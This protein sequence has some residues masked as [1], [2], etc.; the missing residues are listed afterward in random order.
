MDIQLYGKIK[1][2]KIKKIGSIHGLWHGKTI[3]P[4]QVTDV[5]M[6][7]TEFLFDFESVK[8]SFI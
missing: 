4:A 2:R 8:E 6:S 7:M 5:S 3:N 1:Y